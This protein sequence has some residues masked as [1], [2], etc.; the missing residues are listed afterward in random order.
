MISDGLFTEVKK[1]L[2]F[3]WFEWLQ[4]NKTF[5]FWKLDYLWKS[6]NDVPVFYQCSYEIKHANI[7]FLYHFLIIH[8]FFFQNKQKRKKV[9]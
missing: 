2:P 4:L 7:C 5:D 3:T 6:T 1:Y 9:W 8:M